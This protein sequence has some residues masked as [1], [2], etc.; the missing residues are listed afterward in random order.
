[1]SWILS[2][3]RGNASKHCRK[4]WLDGRQEVI[5]IL[6]RELFF[7]YIVNLSAKADSLRKHKVFA[8]TTNALPPI[9]HAQSDVSDRVYESKLDSKTHTNRKSLGTNNVF[10]STQGEPP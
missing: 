3:T 6:L 8:S 7:I 4:K 1:M 2:P 5:D 9:I 10:P